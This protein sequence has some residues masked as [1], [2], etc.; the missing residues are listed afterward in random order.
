MPFFVEMGFAITEEQ[1]HLICE[2]PAKRYLMEK[3]L[4]VANA[5]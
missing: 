2:A 1:E 3:L 5:A 4:R